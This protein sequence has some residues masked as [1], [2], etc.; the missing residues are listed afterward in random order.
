MSESTPQSTALVAAPAGT[1]AVKTYQDLTLSQ[2]GAA[3]TKSGFFRDIRDASQAIVKIMAG[4]ELGMPPVASMRGIHVFEGHVE[5][6][7][8]TMAGLLKASG[9]YRIRTRTPLDDT[10]KAE[11]EFFERVDGQWE[12]V[13]VSRYSLEEAKRAGLLGKKNWQTAP[14]DMLW[15]RA[16]SRG[17]RRYCQDVGLAPV[18]APGEVREAGIAEEEPA[19][20][21]GLSARLAQRVQQAPSAQASEPAPSSSTGNGQSVEEEPAASVSEPEPETQPDPDVSAPSPDDDLFGDAAEEEASPE[22]EEGLRA[23]EIQH[24]LA[25]EASIPWTHAQHRSNTRRKYAGHEDLEQASLDGLVTYREE[26]ER[27]RAGQAQAASTRERLQQALDRKRGEAFS[28]PADLTQGAAS[29]APPD[30]AARF[31]AEVAEETDGGLRKVVVDTEGILSLGPAKRRA[32]RQE[33]L[34]TEALPQA[35]RAHLVA[36]YIHLREQF[37]AQQDEGS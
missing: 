6:S 18:Y 36:Y 32:P 1:Q 19:G 7:G 2:L 13:G 14:A 5:L 25:L 26:I 33:Y 12:S 17:W 4:Q 10:L 20:T 21:P 24:I 23:A 29:P 9:R 11:I 28:E 30:P 15:N 22:T 8:A 16:M 37:E 27:R 35:D 34:G 31:A 3:F